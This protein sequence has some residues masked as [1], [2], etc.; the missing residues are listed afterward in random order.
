MCL[1]GASEVERTVLSRIESKN[2]TVFV[3]WV[4]RVK[5]KRKDVPLASRIIDDPRTRQYWDGSYVTGAAFENT[6]EIGEPAWDVYMAYGRGIRWTGNL[7]PHPT[8]WMHQ[9]GVTN[10]PRL[11]PDVFAAHVNDLLAG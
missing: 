7:P 9:L 10:A 3:V 5:A 8:F 6:L 4:P 1:R 11:D 2:L